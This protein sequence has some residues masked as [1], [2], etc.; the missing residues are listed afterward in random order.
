[1]A[2]VAWTWLW[3]RPARYE[4]LDAILEEYGY[5]RETLVQSPDGREPYAVLGII[6]GHEGSPISG[7]FEANGQRRTFS[8]PAEKGV[9]FEVV[10]LEPAGGGRP[11]FAV[12][13]RP[14]AKA[15]KEQK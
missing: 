14:V 6:V 2:L 10:G 8:M 1:M 11:T 9:F 5:P 15:A 7:S 13:R 4:S 3:H 12:L